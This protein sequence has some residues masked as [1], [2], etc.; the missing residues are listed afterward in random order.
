L[1]KKALKTIEGKILSK[2]RCCKR[3]QKDAKEVKKRHLSEDF[4][5]KRKR[6]GEGGK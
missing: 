6:C 3:E 4:T 5:K 1:E 2:K